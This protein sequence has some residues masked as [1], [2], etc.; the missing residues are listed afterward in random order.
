LQID[1]TA[2]HL[3][4][5]SK[6]D[7]RMAKASTRELLLPESRFPGHMN[8]IELSRAP[9]PPYRFAFVVRALKQHMV[10]RK[11]YAFC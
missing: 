8:E 10:D 4:L 6:S 2:S 3:D 9:L 1:G 5:P 7:A 11:Q